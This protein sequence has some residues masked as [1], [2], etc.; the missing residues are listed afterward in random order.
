MLWIIE[1]D[2][3]ISKLE[4]RVDELRLELARL[5][6]ERNELTPLLH[7]PDE[8]QVHIA[9]AYTADIPPLASDYRVHL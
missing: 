5:K 4:A 1:R 9:V 2:A 6:E 7:L 3:R 8:L